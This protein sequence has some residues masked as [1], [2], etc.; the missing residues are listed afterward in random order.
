MRNGA[1]R[2]G[3]ECR[4]QRKSEVSIFILLSF[5]YLEHTHMSRRGTDRER[6]RER[7]PS[8]LCAVSIELNVGLELMNHKFMT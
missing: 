3:R 4:K 8:R 2:K 7:I 6:E 5:I 1:E